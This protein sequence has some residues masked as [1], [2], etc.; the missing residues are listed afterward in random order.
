LET[1]DSVPP[2]D[3]T[4]RL[5]ALLHD[6]GKPRTK[7]GP[8]FYRHELVGAELSEAIGARLRFPQEVTADVARLVEHHMYAA[9]PR[10]EARTLRRFI[11]RIGPD[12]LERQFAL[13]A[14]DIRG[15]G[16][17]KRGPEN[18]LFETR[19]R[20]VL[21]ERPAL[22]V[23][24]LK[25]SGDDVIAELVARGRLPKGSRGGREVGILLG[26]L[27]EHVTDDPASNDRSKLLTELALLVDASGGDGDVS[28]ETKARR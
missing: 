11:R 7:D 12:L 10:Q 26:K 19:V 16:L 8:H 22:S 1:L 27:L 9:D 28:R 14:A 21:E 17:P 25:L 20:A 15:S 23:R 5:A 3:L 4:L 6:V 18:E 13:R 2:G 24:D